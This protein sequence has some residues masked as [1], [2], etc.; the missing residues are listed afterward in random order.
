MYVKSMRAA[1]KKA[2]LNALLACTT[3]VSVSR[4]GLGSGL[5]KYFWGDI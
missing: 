4:G 1:Q 3:F 2:R 5:A